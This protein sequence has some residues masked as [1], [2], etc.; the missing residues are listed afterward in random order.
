MDEN[1]PAPE[2]DPGKLDAPADPLPDKAKDSAIKKI[3]KW[4]K[5]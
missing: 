3:T 4:L 5:R 2:L 1:P